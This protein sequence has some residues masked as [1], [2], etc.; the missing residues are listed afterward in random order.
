M[1]KR[2]RNRSFIV[3]VDW[4]SIQNKPEGI[5]PESVTYEALNANG[6]VG[7]NEGQVAAGNHDHDVG[8]L[9]QLFNNALV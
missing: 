1:T 6:D 4:D 2:A 7:N 8:D 5:G 9:V 3:N